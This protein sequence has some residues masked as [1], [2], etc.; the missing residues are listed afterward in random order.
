MPPVKKVGFHRPAVMIQI[1]EK[2]SRMTFLASGKAGYIT[3]ESLTIAGRKT[4]I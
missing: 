4:L 2:F 1:L 3:V